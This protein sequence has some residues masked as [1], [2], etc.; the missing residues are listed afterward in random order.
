MTG[1]TV[2]VLG[3]VGRNF[4][5]GMSGGIAY[6]YDPDSSFLENFNPELSDIEKILKKSEDEK[7]LIDLVNNHYNYT[8]SEV[9]N[10]ILKNW[11]S[12]LKYFK[13]IIPRAYAKILIKEKNN[14]R[15]KVNG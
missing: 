6:V 8:S 7:L 2:V 9:A 4:G 5:A 10:R 12:E 3:E 13:K 14:S 15:E 11:D 1:G